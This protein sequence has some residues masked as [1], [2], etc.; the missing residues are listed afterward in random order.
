MR[1]AYKHP[2]RRNRPRET[3][4]HTDLPRRNKRET[5]T[6][7]RV[8]SPPEHREQNGSAYSNLEPL[9]WPHYDITTLC[10][11]GTAVGRGKVLVSTDTIPILAILRVSYFVSR[12]CLTS[13]RYAAAAYGCNPVAGATCSGAH[14]FQ[15]I[16]ASEKAIH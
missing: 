2:P 8:N 6:E 9:L 13:Q 4:S 12:A 15:L 1:S 5:R 7:H 3:G 14:L 10:A 16:G 11:V